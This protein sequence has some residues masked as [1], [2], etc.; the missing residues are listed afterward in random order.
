MYNDAITPKKFFMKKFAF[1]IPVLFFAVSLFIGSKFMSS[2]S[3]SPVFMIVGMLG[4]LVAVSLFRPKPKQSVK[5]A[6]DLEAEIRGDFAKDAFQD[7]QELNAKFQ[8]ALK[9]YSGNMPKAAYNKLL[10]L[11]PLCRND[12]ERYAVAMATAQVQMTLG[13]FM[14]AARQY[15]TA[16]IM[17]PSSDLAMKQGS[18]YQRVGE[19]DKARSAYTYALDLDEGNLEAHSAIATT[20]VADR[21]YQE[22]L[23]VALKVLEKDENHAS[24]LATTAICYGLL[25]DFEMSRYYADRAENNGYSRKKINDTIAALKK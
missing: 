8:S 19:L 9:D 25:D 5:P 12:Q 4:I 2:G 14:D 7:D 17:C 15:T 21:M 3:I 10:K 16:L 24:S 23:G 1:L 11:A 13:K 6:G 22:A 20:Y 18:C